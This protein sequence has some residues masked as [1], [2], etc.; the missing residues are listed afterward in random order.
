LALTVGLN[1]DIGGPPP[2]AEFIN[3]PSFVK[4]IKNITPPNN[5]KLT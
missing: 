3:I 5:V 4:K 1:V 2:C